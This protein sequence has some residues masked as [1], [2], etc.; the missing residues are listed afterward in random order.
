MINDVQRLLRSA[1]KDY[2]KLKATDSLGVA[3]DDKVPREECMKII[4]L[5]IGNP[6]NKE[7]LFSPKF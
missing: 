7:I 2:W 1:V 4:E 3:N 6:Q 5:L